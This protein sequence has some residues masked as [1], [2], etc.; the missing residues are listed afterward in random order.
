MAGY[1]VPIASETKAFKQ[2]IE[3]GIIKPVEDANK[4]LKE[5]GENR[6]PEQLERD[7]RDAQKTTEKLADETKGTA[8]V[9][10]REYRDSFRKVKA[11]ADDA[12]DGIKR[13]ANEAKDEVT[14]TAREGAA[15]FTGEWTDVGDVVQESLANAFAAFGPGG[16][17][18]GILAA[19]GAGALITG[20]QTAQEDTDKLKQRFSDMYQSAAEEGRKFLDSA[21]IQ[22]EALSLIFDPDRADEYKRLVDEASR[23]GVDSSTY[24]RAIA[25]DEDAINTALEI[26][27]AKREERQEWAEKNLQAE[28]DTGTITD[29]QGSAMDNVL[30]KLDTRLKLT[31]ENK[32]K[33]ALALQVEKDINDANAEGNRKAKE[34]IDVRGAALDEFARKAASIPNPVLVPDVDTRTA[35]GKLSEFIRRYRSP[36]ELSVI[37]KDQAGRQILP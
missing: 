32:E 22:G 28:R 25:G 35:D 29:E 5:L 24:I 10:E 33:A 1:T 21:A 18:V 13:G 15:S 26:G 3:T 6:G 12:H 2:G 30:A 16:A 31:D 4:E 36:L 37:Y 9:I 19:A 27:N 7:L 11:S 14:S 17:L 23:I 20:L 8:R 34:A